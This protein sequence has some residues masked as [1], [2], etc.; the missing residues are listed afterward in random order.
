V[1][2]IFALAS[3][4]FGAPAAP[5]DAKAAPAA[6]AKV[7]R[8]EIEKVVNCPCEDNCGKLLA[9]CICDFT[10]GMRKEI[11]AMIAAGM[12]KD[13]ILA[14]LVKHYGKR[15]LA[16][17]G[18]KAW[19]DRLAWAAPFLALAAGLWFLLRKLRGLTR[20]AAAGPEPLGETA[21]APPAPAS[22]YD[23]RL[24]EE[25]SRFES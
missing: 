17:P 9:N 3:P 25:L 2:A 16:Q 15:V 6:K 4:A 12:T 20:P 24:E 19:L 14:A 13:E 18:G 10:R 5:P 11:D 1:L 7:T 8:P 23:R 21:P 22:S